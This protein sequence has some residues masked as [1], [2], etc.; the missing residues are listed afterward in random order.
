MNSVNEIYILLGSS[1]ID[2][3][4]KH[5]SKAIL[6][7][8]VQ[9]KYSSYNGVFETPNRIQDV[10]VFDFPIEIGEAIISLH[11]ITTNGGHNKRNKAKFTVTPDK[12]FEIEFIWDE[13]WQN[14]VDR[15][16]SIEV[17]KDPSYIPPKWHWE[18]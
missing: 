4:P 18:K 16:N 8:E 6:T 13:E 12:Q 9:P 5:W 7:L 1:I 3:S 14:E 11:R 2:N 10:S 15:K 17:A